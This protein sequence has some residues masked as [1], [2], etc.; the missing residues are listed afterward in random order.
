MIKALL[1]SLAALS[2]LTVLAT[3]QTAVPHPF[4]LH[5]I[6]DE[7]GPDRT[8]TKPA[9]DPK[10]RTVYLEKVSLMDESGIES[11]QAASGRYGWE[12]LIALTPKGSK[13]FTAIT[14]D[15]VGKQI[16]IVLE[17]KFVS[18]PRINEPIQGPSLVISGSFKEQDAKDLAAKLNAAV[19]KAK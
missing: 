19:K 18:A 4:E 10:A 14:T 13:Q 12:I 6:F 2:S 7:A 11:A 15:N 8:E 3:A 17:G 1:A 5:R 16:G 9:N